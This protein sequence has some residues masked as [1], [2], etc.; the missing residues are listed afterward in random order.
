MRTN[1]T[2]SLIFCLL[3]APNL[4]AQYWKATGALSATGSSMYLI[5]ATHVEDTIYVLSAEQNIAYSTDQGVTWTKQTIDKPNGNFVSITGIKDR[6]YASTKINTYDFELYYSM[7]KGA[8]WQIDTIGLP[9]SLTNT[10][11]SGMILRYMGNDYVLAYNYSKAVLKKLGETNWKPTSIDNVIVDI[12]ASDNKWLAIGQGKMLESTDNGTSWTSINTNGLP[13][14]FQGSLITTNGSRIF[15]SNDPASGGQTIYYSDDGGSN[16]TVTNSAG[17]FSYDNPW[18]KSIHAVGDYVFA[19]ISPKFAD[20]ESAPPFIVSS[21]QEPDFSVGDV[22]GLPTGKT[23]TSLP[24]FFHVGTK[25]FTM[26]WDLYS[27]EPGFSNEVKTAIKQTIGQ[28]QDDFSFFPNPVTSEIHIKSGGNLK[29]I[30]SNGV[31]VRNLT[32]KTE[33]LNDLPAGFYFLAS[34]SGIVRKLVKQ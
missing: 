1:F 25:L 34:E 2:L 24:F 4:F 29:L 33:S 18:V 21:T 27:S 15:V 3:L 19:A 20:F 26:F 6:L 8:S 7:D 12:T 22:S 14:N 17:K 9:P 31:F 5:G 13:A 10:G 28:K 11:K 32:E 16:W 30:N 23:N